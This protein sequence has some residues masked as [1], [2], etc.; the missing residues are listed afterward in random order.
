MSAH[1]RTLLA[2]GLMLV[3]LLLLGVAGASYARAALAQAELKQRWDEQPVLPLGPGTQ[4]TRPA[5]AAADTMPDFGEGEPVA[6]IRIPRIGLDAVVLE[7]ISSETLAVAPGHYPGMPQPGDGGHAVLSAH[8]D[9]FFRHLGRLE[10][11]DRIQVKRWDGREV[12]YA[13]SRAFIV[14]KS[15]RTVIVPRDREVLTLITCYPFVYAG[16]APYRYIVEAEPAGA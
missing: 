14:H 4:A 3:G 15:N 16:A 11:G 13:V 6:R 12:S 8:R 1:P 2:N 9:S 10:E 5:G 7:G